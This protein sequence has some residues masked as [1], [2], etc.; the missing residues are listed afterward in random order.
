MKR[1]VAM[2]WRKEYDG[3][4]YYAEFRRCC[5]NISFV[6]KR[7]VKPM[8]M[9][10]INVSDPIYGDTVKTLKEAVKMC[11]SYYDRMLKNE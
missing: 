7:Y 5:G 2:E 1:L 10:T 8:Y 9:S 3:G 6:L 11:D 4:R